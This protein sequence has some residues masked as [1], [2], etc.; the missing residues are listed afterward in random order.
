MGRFLEVSVF[1]FRL[2]LMLLWLI[3]A[4]AIAFPLA[5]VRWKNAENNFLFGKI[6]GR[7]ARAIM[8][9]RVHVEGAEHLE[10]RP[11]VFV[12]N[13]QSGL[14]L[15]VLATVYPKGAVI[16]AKKELRKIPVFGLMFEAFGNVMI[17][18]ADRK[19]ALAELNDAV[20]EMKAR[21]LSVWVFA[22]GTRNASGEGLLPFKKG[23]F[24]MA[25]QLQAPVVSIVCSRIERLVNFKKKYARSGNLVVRV[26]PPIST[27]GL[28]VNEVVPLLERT[29]TQMLGTLLEIS[30][31]A[32]SLD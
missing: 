11:A 8:G 15:A 3:L 4:S 21:N 2:T 23:A 16:I 28:S 9:L 24:Y 32:K 30:E 22:E 26:L 18:R 10:N 19:N 6:Y 1:Y 31:R 14:D 12:V 17:N 20:I 27:Q 25:L 29:R 7:I 13:H 5:L